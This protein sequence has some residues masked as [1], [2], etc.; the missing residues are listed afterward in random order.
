MMES[1]ALY[2]FAVTHEARLIREIDFHILITEYLRSFPHGPQGTREERAS[3]LLTSRIAS[4][5]NILQISCQ[6]QNEL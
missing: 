3:K 1:K 4:F 5:E 2:E 6:N